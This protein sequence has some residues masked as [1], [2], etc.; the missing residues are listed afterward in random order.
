MKLKD[1]KENYIIPE[2]PKIDIKSIYIEPKQERFIFRRL[3]LQLGLSMVFLLFLGLSFFVKSPISLKP[4]VLEAAELDT[5]SVISSSMMFE[6][7]NKNILFS[8]RETTS[9]FEEK[10]PVINPYVNVF[11]IFVGINTPE[12]IQLDA[13]A[14][15]GYDYYQKIIIK[16]SLNND[17]VYHYHYKQEIDD[18]ELEQSGI[19]IHNEEIYYIEIELENEHGE[20]EKEFRIYKDKLKKDKDYIYL[21][22]EQEVDEQSFHYSVYKGGNQVHVTKVELNTDDKQVELQLLVEIKTSN[23]LKF[24]MRLKLQGDRFAGYYKIEN[25][26]N[27]SGYITLQVKK[28]D[29]RYVYEYTISNKKVIQ[30]RSTK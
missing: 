3:S 11:E 25:D 24:S 26:K 4:V 27:E 17:I 2:K 5:F 10:L 13:D 12:I 22:I 7:T 28:D 19:L 16:D 14:L 29:D 23:P 6:E 20:I 18:D 9:L 15:T 8:S 30:T 21:E 1:M